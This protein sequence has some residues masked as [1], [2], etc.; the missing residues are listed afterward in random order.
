[1]QIV[2]KLEKA[3]AESYK[4]FTKRQKEEVDLLIR[5]IF[6]GKEISKAVKQR[7][8]N[9]D[10]LEL[11]ITIFLQNACAQNY[12]A[13][14]RTIPKN[15]RLK[16]RFLVKNYIKELMKIQGKWIQV[17]QYGLTKKIKPRDSLVKKYERLMQS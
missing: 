5:D 11:E 8:V 17:Y 2:I 7:V 13:P 6:E 10:A 9:F 15:Q 4:Q 14:N 12:F 1:M 16:W 3:F